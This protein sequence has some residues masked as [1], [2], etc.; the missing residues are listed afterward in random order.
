MAVLEQEIQ[1]LTTAQKVE[2]MERIW[3]DLLRDQDDIEVP[4]WHL[5]A[6]DETERSLE[7]GGEHFQDWALAKNLIREA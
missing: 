4:A 2:I 7:A 3:A 5:D 1:A 6:L